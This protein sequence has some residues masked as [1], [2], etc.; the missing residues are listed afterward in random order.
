MTQSNQFTFYGGGHRGTEA[1][2]GRLA[3]LV[4]RS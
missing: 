4:R 2:F 3:E 1:E